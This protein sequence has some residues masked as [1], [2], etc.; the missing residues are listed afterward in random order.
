[1][2]APPARAVGPKAAA[3]AHP[4]ASGVLFAVVAANFFANLDR[5]AFTFLIEPIRLD[6]QATDTQIGLLSSSA[7]VVSYFIF[8]IPIARWADVGARRTILVVSIAIWSVMTILCG[9]A[10]SIL[11]MALFRAGLGIAES[12]AAPASMSMLA[13]CYPRA[14]RH[15]AVSWFQAGGTLAPLLGIPALAALSTAFGWRVA[16]FGAGLAGLSLSAILWFTLREPR[17][18]GFDDI[19]APPPTTLG[20]GLAALVTSKPFVLHTLSHVFASASLSIVITWIGAYMMRGFAF[21]LGQMAGMLAVGGVLLSASTLITGRICAKLVET[22]LDDRWIA[23]VCTLASLITIPATAA[24]LLA[25]SIGWFIAGFCASYLVMAV[26]IPPTLTLAA[27]LV[28]PNTRALA[29]SI[30]VGLSSLLGAGLAPVVAGRLSDHLALA[31]GEVEAL[32]LALLYTSL[33]CLVI[34]VLFGGL[35]IR[36]VGMKAAQSAP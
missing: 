31:V 18:G 19:A 35:S 34:A 12:G 29:T 14:R 8:G 17:R 25:P 13:D 28:A 24:M 36:F 5:F 7:F 4:G 26:R 2:S 9:F 30:V 27:E 21:S 16:L 1:M 33:P 32:R 15:Q 22:K 3:A 6:L 23:G 10:T 20:R 11:M